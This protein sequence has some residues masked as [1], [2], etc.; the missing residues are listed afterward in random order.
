[1]VTNAMFEVFNG[2]PSFNHSDIIKKLKMNLSGKEAYELTKYITLITKSVEAKAYNKRGEEILKEFD[3][4][5]KDL[6]IEERRPPL[7]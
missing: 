6:P 2:N 4:K 7:I 3:D 1:M 5:Q